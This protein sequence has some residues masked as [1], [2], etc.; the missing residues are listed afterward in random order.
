MMGVGDTQNMWSDLAVKQ[1]L[2]RTA[3]H[4]S[5]KYINITWAAQR[6][7]WNDLRP[8]KILTWKMLRSIRI[9]MEK[10]QNKILK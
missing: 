2:L 4:W 1:R 8:G 6:S 10:P 5:S 9:I 7:R 3:S